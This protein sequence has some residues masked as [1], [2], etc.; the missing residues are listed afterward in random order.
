MKL[1]FSKMDIGTF[2]FNFVRALMVAPTG[3]AEVSECLQAA[4]AIQDH[5]EES[6]VCAWAGLAEKTMRIGEIALRQPPPAR[7]FC[8]PA[9]I[10]G[11]PC[12]H[13]HPAMT[14]STATFN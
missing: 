2:Q 5:D 14:V 9:I 3:G 4:A 6:W 12:S 1:D 10:T 11:P 7:L 8:E 13:Y